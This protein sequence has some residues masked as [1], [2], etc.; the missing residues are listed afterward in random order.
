MILICR[1]IVLEGENF[2]SPK[3]T[4]VFS[5]VYTWRYFCLLFYISLYRGRRSLCSQWKLL[6]AKGICL[7]CCTWLVIH[8][9]PLSYPA[10]TIK[11]AGSIWAADDVR[12]SQL[13]PLALHSRASFAPGGE[14]ATRPVS[15]CSTVDHPLDVRRW[16]PPDHTLNVIFSKL[17]EGQY[18]QRI[19]TTLYFKSFKC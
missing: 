9:N 12:H 14:A 17:K 15:P 4:A 1:K 18:I 16:K 2:L 11:M 3:I 19:V 7:P 5:Q 13:C 8:T 10:L 6:F